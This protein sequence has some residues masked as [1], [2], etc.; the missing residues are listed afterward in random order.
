[1]AQSPLP[2]VSCVQHHTSIDLNRLADCSELQLVADAD[3]TVIH[4]RLW[5]RDLKLACYFSHT[6]IVRGRSRPCQGLVLDGSSVPEA[7]WNGSPLEYV[8]TTYSRPTYAPNVSNAS[9]PNLAIRVSAGRELF[10]LTAVMS[11][12]IQIRTLDFG[13]EGGADDARKDIASTGCPAQCFRADP[14]TRSGAGSLACAAGRTS[15]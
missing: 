6:L 12:P 3:A 14:H 5:Q 4:E 9:N 15:G 8:R 13:S 2:H 10:R 7:S 11:L 1:M